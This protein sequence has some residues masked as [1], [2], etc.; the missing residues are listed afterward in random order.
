MFMRYVEDVLR[1]V[2]R[3]IGLRVLALVLASVLALVIYWLGRL[4]SYEGAL[5]WGIIIFCV[6]LWVLW[7]SVPLEMVRTKNVR[8]HGR[9][10]EALPYCDSV[11][12]V[13]ESGAEGTDA[14]AFEDEVGRG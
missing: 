4:A 11:S 5:A 6:S 14:E 10:G 1:S 7:P 2:V 3:A 8:I 13:G 12:E 9:A